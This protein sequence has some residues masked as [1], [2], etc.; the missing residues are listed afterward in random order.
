MI[1]ITFTLASLGEHVPLQL[2]ATI[3]ALSYRLEPLAIDMATGMEAVKHGTI[4]VSH[5][6]ITS[7]DISRLGLA[8]TGSGPFLDGDTSAVLSLEAILVISSM[9][10]RH[11]VDFVFTLEAINLPWRG[12]MSPIVRRQLDDFVI[13][14]LKIARVKF[15]VAPPISSQPGFYYN[16]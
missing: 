6:A 11:L 8:D 15:K 5:R 7:E 9:L 2:T 1:P 12:S 14:L 13:R 3:M 10:R 4:Q 16:G